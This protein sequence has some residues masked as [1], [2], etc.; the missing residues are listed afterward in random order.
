MSHPFLDAWHRPGQIA[1]LWPGDAPLQVGH[2]DA[3]IP[4]LR[5][6]P[7]PSDARGL[8]IV[9]P[10]GGYQHLAPHEGEPVARW[11]NDCG[12][13]AAVLRYRHAPTYQH[14]APLLDA[15]RAVRVVRFLATDA[16]YD[17]DPVGILGFSAGGHLAA[18]IS[19]HFDDGSARSD[20]PIE[21]H[22]S[23]PDVSVLV[24]PVITLNPPS[25]HTGSRKNLIGMDAP[26]SLVD[27]L[28]N[29][30]RVTARTPP[31]FI[32]HTFGDPSVPC[33]NALLY[34]AACRRAGVHVELHLFDVDGLHGV[35]LARDDRFHP[36]L[37]I[38][39]DLCGKWLSG[40]GFGRRA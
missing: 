35:G 20:D 6:F 4:A 27:E 21:R 32:F 13:H 5:F 31:A 12:I 1:P 24:Y 39:P 25:A 23:R 29:D 9:C 7:G 30:Q 8:M 28:S 19:N 15:A 3:D 26:Q 40:K 11:L 10:G 36:I 34:A 16:G 17:G 18:T 22:S 38:W 37:H 14:P 33:E 2:A